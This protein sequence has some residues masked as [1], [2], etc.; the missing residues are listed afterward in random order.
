M[1]IIRPI[2]FEVKN[3]GKSKLKQFLALLTQQKSDTM[4]N[5]PDFIVDSLS[6]ATILMAFYTLFGLSGFQWKAQYPSFQ[7]Q[8]MNF[9]IQVD[10]DF[11]KKGGGSFERK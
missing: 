5:N 11:A 9:N 10:G 1:D 2:I 8:L 4:N 7:F 3:C 6:K